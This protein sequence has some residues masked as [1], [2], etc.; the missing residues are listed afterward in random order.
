MIFVPFSAG[1]PS[2][3]PQDVLT[4]FRVGD[5][6]YGRPVQVAI[7]AKGALFVADDVGNTVWRVSAASNA[8]AT[9]TASAEGEATAR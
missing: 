6:A 2:A 7:G 1:R 4:G 5:V 3:P 9:H 8:P